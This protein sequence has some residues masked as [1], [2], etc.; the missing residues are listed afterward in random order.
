MLSARSCRPLASVVNEAVLAPA[1]S[2]I[3]G[4]PNE[5]PFGIVAAAEA[6]GASVK[7][8]GGGGGVVTGALLSPPPPPPP[9]PQL[10]RRRTTA[11]ATSAAVWSPAKR[12]DTGDSS[13]D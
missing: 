12:G 9:P 13:F 6:A 5:V 11:G 8:S 4:A 1:V 2:A 10:A 3:A 7:V